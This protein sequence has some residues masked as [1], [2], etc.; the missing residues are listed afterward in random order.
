MSRALVLLCCT[1]LARAA[2]A[3]PATRT[4]DTVNFNVVDARTPESRKTE[5]LSYWVTSCRYGVLRLGDNLIYPDRLTDLRSDLEDRLQS[6]LSGTTLTVT[7]FDVYMNR[8]ATF[9]AQ[10]PFAKSP[11]GILVA[12]ATTPRHCA[13]EPGYFD[14]SEVNSDSATPIVVEIE[15][16]L[17]GKTYRARA[18]FSHGMDAGDFQHM[19]EPDIAVHN[20]DRALADALENDLGK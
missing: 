7:K 6:K 20:A 5:W 8:A 3:D 13:G 10:N 1:L 16:S 18:V 2:L 15:V 4:A 19:P 11:I 14:R 12:A 9:A 17:G